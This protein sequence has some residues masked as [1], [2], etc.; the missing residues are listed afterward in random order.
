MSSDTSK[1]A[2]AALDAAQQQ[3]AAAGRSTL[4]EHLRAV[5]Q[6]RVDEELA[7]LRQS[8]VWSEPDADYVAS[9]RRSG[10]NES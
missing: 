3:L 6:R 8:G 4:E 5:A 9:V 7:A 1:L 2:A 10:P